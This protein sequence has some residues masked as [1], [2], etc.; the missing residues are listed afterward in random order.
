ME[1]LGHDDLPTELNTDYYNRP[2]AEGFMEHLANGMLLMQGP[3]GTMLMSEVGAQDIPPTFWN[4]GEP[5]M[6]RRLHLLYG[7]AGAQGDAAA[8]TG[9]RFSP[10]ED[11]TAPAGAAGR[12][13][14]R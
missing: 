4:L 9:T 11:G 2:G 10:K 8:G 5:Q 6:V 14:G 13:E 7:A 3:M 12:G 1:A